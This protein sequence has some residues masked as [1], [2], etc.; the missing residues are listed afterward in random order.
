MRTFVAAVVIFLGL[1]CSSPVHAE[2]TPARKLGR[3]IVN[4]VTAPLE[5]PKQT[6]LYWKQGAKKTPHI[7]VWI[8]SGIGRGCVDTVRRVGSGVWDVVTFPVDIPH[9]YEPLVTPDYVFQGC[10]NLWNSK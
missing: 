1:V 10:E 9:H 3:G 8:I 2:S 4:I 5:I 7:I 6:R